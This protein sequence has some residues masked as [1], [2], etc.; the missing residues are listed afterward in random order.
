ME[1][2]DKMD[3]TDRSKGSADASAND[4]Q[5]KHEDG[6]GRSDEARGFTGM[7]TLDVRAQSDTYR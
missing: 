2:G 4:V 7:Q 1:N 5:F 6:T 3:S